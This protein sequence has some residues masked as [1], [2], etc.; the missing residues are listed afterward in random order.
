MAARTLPARRRRSCPPSAMSRTWRPTSTT[1][2][3]TSRPAPTAPWAVAGRSACAGLSRRWDGLEPVAAASAVLGLL[4]ALLAPAPR[5]GGE[6]GRA[7]RPLGAAGSAP[8]RTTCRSRTRPGE[9][10]EN[11]IAEL[12]AQRLGVQVDY[13]WYPQSMGFVRNTLRAQLL[14]PDHGRGRGRRAGPEQQPLLPLDLRPG[15]IRER[16][17]SERLADLDSP[18]DRSWPASASSPA[19]PPADLLLR[20]GL[21]GRAQ[22]YHLIVDTRVEKPARQM[23]EDLRRRARSTWR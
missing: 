21:I 18:T 11:K 6:H 19:R 22:A 9:G 23:I 2:T 7:G 10:F 13:T 16:A 5:P 14:R 17:T 1:S 12:M 15:L 4:A 8:I 20:K 3:P